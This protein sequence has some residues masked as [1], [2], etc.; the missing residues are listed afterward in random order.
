EI[1]DTFGEQ[2]EALMAE[3]GAPPAGEPEGVDH[4][5]TAA[6]LAGDAAEEAAAMRPVEPAAPAGCPPPSGWLVPRSKRA[7]LAAQPELLA[8]EAQQVEGEEAKADVARIE[9]AKAEAR[10]AA[11]EQAKAAALQEAQADT[12]HEARREAAA[13]AVEDALEQAKAEA[14][15]EAQAEIEQIRAQALEQARD[16]ALQKAKADALEA[17]QQAKAE[18][19][20]QAKAEA[21]QQ[22]R[23]QVAA[24]AAEAARAGEAPTA[25][26]DAPEPPLG[27]GAAGDPAE[28]VADEA[29][30]REK[31]KKKL[32][33]VIDC[34]AR[35]RQ[36][37][38]G[39][40]PDDEAQAIIDEAEAK[41]QATMIFNERKRVMA[42]K[43]AYEQEEKEKAEALML[44]AEL[45]EYEAMRNQ[46][47]EVASTTASDDRRLSGC[48]QH[49]V[50]T[51]SEYSETPCVPELPTF[52][53]AMS[54][55]EK[56]Q[57]AK[58]RLD[59]LHEVPYPDSVDHGDVPQPSPMTPA[60]TSVRSASLPRAE[61]L[62]AGESSGSTPQA[63]A[64]ARE[65]ESPWAA[66]SAAAYPPAQPPA[67]P[68]P[69][70]AQPP[71]PAPDA[72]MAPA[73]DK[74]TLRQQVVQ[75]MDRVNDAAKVLASCAPE[76]FVLE[77]AAQKAEVSISQLCHSDLVRKMKALHQADQELSMDAKQK[78]L[79][80]ED[81]FWE[82]MKAHDFKFG[83]A[84]TSGNSIAGRWARA[85]R[86]DAALAAEY[87]AKEGYLQKAD[88]RAAWAKGK[89]DKHQ[90]ARGRSKDEKHSKSEIRN[91]TYVS[92]GR[93]AWLEGGGSS[94]MKIAVRY[95]TNCVIMGG[96]WCSW[97]EMGEVLKYLHVQHSVRDEFKRSWRAWEDWAEQPTAHASAEG[98]A[99]A[100]SAPAATPSRAGG[101]GDGDGGIPARVISR[102]P[103]D[104]GRK[105]KELKNSYQKATSECNTILRMVKSDPDWCWADNDVMMGPLRSAD[106]KVH[107][108]L[109]QDRDLASCLAGQFANLKSTLGDEKV[110]AV[111]G[112]AVFALKE[113][114]EALDHECRL[115]IAQHN[116]R[117]RLVSLPEKANLKKARKASSSHGSR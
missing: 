46:R 7:R 23:L 21:L 47:W 3:A 13:K 25:A 65:T 69:Q 75:Q 99:A 113:P 63:S 19:I 87:R 26:A 53:F 9:Q 74:E 66:G 107:E 58:D 51:D 115:L 108:I 16:E 91:G 97:D 42:K 59:E 72:P 43:L 45:D 11:F 80:E 77:D 110:Q 95:A 88:F 54:E 29:A 34:K 32:H 57:Q 22:A 52:E 10:A 73:T 55:R 104:N 28:E 17:A 103:D 101:G 89:Y 96:I 114:V 1:V 27:A 86:A 117:V 111:L 98:D 100:Q 37:G 4:A 68:Q 67:Q 18:A 78:A 12:L 31:Q 82:G 85:L 92:L 116:S 81:A 44:E 15:Q 61:P 106:S 90:V 93:L 6:Q 33:R 105:F 38:G 76:K 49:D 60:A 71:Q 64:P 62:A 36:R 14:L 30:K 70:P 102:K 83:T 94:G 112:R 50:D 8:L 20:Q 40:S 24:E 41:R 48:N 2:A 35:K 109:K 5:P 84:C 79:A 56:E 39:I